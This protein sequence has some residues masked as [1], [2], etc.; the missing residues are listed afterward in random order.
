MTEEQT[1]D[2]VV[3]GAGFAGLYMLHRLR[4]SG[5]R[6]VVLEAADGV[7]GTWYW[8]RYP[9]ARCDSESYYYSYS[10]DDDLQQEWTWSERYAGQEE[11]R[12]YLDHVADRFDL[13]RDIRLN[14]RVAAT[15]WD[16]E[17]GL[18]NVGTEAGDTVRGRYLVTAVGCLSSAN[19]PDIPGLDS[20]EGDWYHTGQWP[21][22]KVDFSGKRV[23]IVGTGSTGIQAIP[24]IAAEAAHLTV[25]QRTP[26]YSIPARNGPMSPEVSAK[27]KQ[28]YDRIRAVQ[29][30]ST[31]GHPFLINETSALAVDDDVRTATYESAWEFGGLRFRAT[32]ADLLADKA[33]NDTA[34]DFIRNKIREIVKD[35]EVAE[36]LLPKD[37]GFAT[38][39]PPI[40]TE[41]FET[42]NRDN[43]TLV[44]VRATPIQEI[45][46]TGMRTSE[47]EYPL[48]CIVFA[49][50]FDALTGPLLRMNI[51]GRDGVA[52]RDRWAEGPKT[53]LGLQVAGFP[54][55]FTITGPG[56]PSV[57]TNMPTCIEQH[58]EWIID[59]LE[60]MRDKGLDRV[61]T[62]EDAE[63]EWGAEVA[64]AADRTLLP[65][66]STSWYLGANVPGKPRV[67]MP[68]AGGMANYA[69]TCKE[70]AVR[71]YDGF[72]MT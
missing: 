70:V 13:R 12:R 38:K 58:V 29:R 59:C 28:E 23:G 4:R 56:S 39:R 19:V 5:M 67:F 33:A 11:I 54:N 50:G 18:W 14:T 34:S 43:V 25:F 69:K 42:Y 46:P 65:Q 45:T 55:M 35:P 31:N 32:Y 64:R 63:R 47:H 20:F 1:V 22:E 41:Y 48:D 53:Y 24:V 44:D 60:H 62:T 9:G 30:A 61:E 72:V 26:N 49:T 36:R 16:E 71:G 52:L 37:H 57:L 15:S 10:F 27:I 17:A 40:D 2:V 68:Y 7:G 66:A 8:N 21:H 6:A 3:V 51:R